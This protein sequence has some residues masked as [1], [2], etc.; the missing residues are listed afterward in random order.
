MAPDTARDAHHARGPAGWLC[1]ATYFPGVDGS[2]L[3]APVVL[4]RVRLV[5]ASPAPKNW[6]RLMTAPLALLCCAAFAGEPSP[7]EYLDEDTGATVTVVEEPLVFEY[8]RRDLAA[9]GHDYATLAAAS[10]NRG[11]KVEYVLIVYFWSTVDPRLRTD[12]LPVAEPLILQADDRRISLK[13]RGHSA[14]EA[15][16]GTAI[17]APPVGNA[18]PNV[19]GTDLATVR[20]IGAARQLTL[21]ADSDGTTLSYG[22]W[23]DRRPALQQFVRHMSGQD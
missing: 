2:V 21:L 12:S 8:G 17:H 18:R 6:R 14:H 20:F 9:N 4:D 16:I 7:L 5:L 10:V 3:W 13:L 11:G 22:L 15:G 1:N 23:T 19:Y